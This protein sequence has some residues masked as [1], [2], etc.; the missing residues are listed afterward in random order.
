MCIDTQ[1]FEEIYDSSYIDSTHNW[2]NHVLSQSKG[3]NQSSLN[4]GKGKEA[5]LQCSWSLHP[6]SRVNNR[7]MNYNT[8]KQSNWDKSLDGNKQKYFNTA[9]LEGEIIKLYFTIV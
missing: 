2:L 7:N 9:N 4:A 3:E 1:D 8:I 6:N 5:A